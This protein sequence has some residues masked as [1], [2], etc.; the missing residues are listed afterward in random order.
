MVRREKLNY[1]YEIAGS[2]DEAKECLTYSKYDLVITDYQLGDGNAVALFDFLKATPFIFATGGGDEEIAVKALKAGAF[3][4]LIKDQ[5]RN[6]LKV[7]PLTIENAI[8]RSKINERLRLLE[9][10]V[11][12]ANDAVVVA[13][14]AEGPP[15]IMYINRAF[16]E[17]SNYKL[18]DIY[19]KSMEIFQGEETASEE[20]SKIRQAFAN[21]TS[22]QSELI[23]YRKDQTP[24]WAG[25]SIV[26]LKDQHGKTTHFVSIQ[27][28]ITERKETEKAQ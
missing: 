22:V 20:I 2:L 3:D 21:S 14:T 5:E 8:N 1:N 7:L 18:E 17:M 12:N 13:S 4:Y 15:K 24:Y 25:L 23:L 27:R 16:T 10:V 9:S 26:P 11:V 19:D 28:D 6:Y